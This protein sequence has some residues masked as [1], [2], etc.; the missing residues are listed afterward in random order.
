MKKSLLLVILLL[1]TV[2]AAV[3]A[4]LTYLPESDYIDG[5]S[6]F[7]TGAVTGYVEYAVYDTAF[8][9]LEGYDGDERYVY[10]YQVFHTGGVDIDAIAILGFDPLS[11]TQ[12][13]LEVSD[14][15]GSTF[16]SGVDAVALLD[17]EDVE[18]YYVFEGGVL[19]SDENSWFLLMYSDSDWVKG[20]YEIN[21]SDTDIPVSGDGDG[22]DTGDS[23]VPEPATLALLLGGGLLSLIR[24]K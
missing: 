6:V 11:I 1:L 16:T 3:Q 8:Q 2:P 7:N 22:V 4:S 12:E 19:I 18:A 14:E 10:A 13:S 23:T 9:D 17:T 24:K 5:V 21:P 20:S 15:L